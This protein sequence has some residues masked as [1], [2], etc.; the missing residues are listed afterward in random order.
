MHNVEKP[1]RW[2]ASLGLRPNPPRA[3]PL[4]PT[5]GFETLWKPQY[6]ACSENPMDFLA[7]KLDLLKAI[8]LVLLQ[9]IY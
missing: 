5:K 3:L 6:V 1:A 2:R 8:L 7:K 4:D 9:D